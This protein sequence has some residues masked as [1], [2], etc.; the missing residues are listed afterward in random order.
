M[1]TTLRPYTRHSFHLLAGLLTLSLSIPNL[2]SADEAPPVNAPPATVT[3]V[4]VTPVL[5]SKS[6]PI[7]PAATEKEIEWGKKAAESIAKDPK[8]KILDPQKDDKTKALS[9]KL[10][11]CLLYTS[12]LPTNREV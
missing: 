1:K 2:V 6:K 11:T 12:T 4:T 5:D 3:P 10:N 9:A 8:F 7:P